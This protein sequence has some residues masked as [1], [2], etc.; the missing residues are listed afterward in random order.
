MAGVNKTT[1]HRCARSKAAMTNDREAK[2]FAGHMG[3]RAVLVDILIDKGIVGQEEANNPQYWRRRAADV[4][5][6]A[7]VETDPTTKLK[8]QGIA[9]SYDELADRIEARVPATPKPNDK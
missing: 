6:A 3:V 5:K 1:R 9:K 4:R 8:L 2:L 7:D